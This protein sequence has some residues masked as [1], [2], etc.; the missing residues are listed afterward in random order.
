MDTMEELP[1]MLWG[2]DPI[3]SA[4]ARLHISDI[5]HMKES[6]QVPD[7][8]FY[9]SHPIYNVDV[10]GT[11]VYKKEREDF[12]CYGV[13][14]GTGVINCLCWKN[15]PIKEGVD[16]AWGKPSAGFQGGFN[17]AAELK[18]MR[19]A[20]KSH[21]H[22]EIGDLLRIR[23]PVKTSRQQREITASTYYKVNDPVMSVQIEWMIEVLKLYREFYDKP[24]DLQTYMTNESPV[25]S[26]SKATNILK[27]FFEQ[28]SVSKFRPYDVQDLLLPLITSCTE[29]APGQQEPVAG[30]SPSQQ[31]SMLLKEALEVL[32]NEGIV[33]RKVKSQDEV[34]LVTAQDKDLLMAVKD[35]IRE[36][37]KRAMYREKGCHILHI[38]SSVRQRYSLNVSKT[39]LEL[40]LKLLECNSDIVSTRDNYFTI[41]GLD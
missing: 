27:D 8:Y 35:I 32:Q 4:F 28:G 39:E 13:D 25:S 1:S 20:Q 11:V 21:C 16:C 26:L 15:D 12:F 40:V 6:C 5:H 30:P 3:F 33:Y 14:D 37:S 17:L 29:I 41:F 38:L 19:Q 9:K 34:Y 36:D 22:L 24:L 7:I 10:L 23:G 2:L 31:L 18:K